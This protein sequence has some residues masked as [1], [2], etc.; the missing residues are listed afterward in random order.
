MQVPTFLHALHR[1]EL[2]FQAVGPRAE[3]VLLHDALYINK[4][5][6][7]LP[8]F[9]NILPADIN[10]RISRSDELSFTAT[11]PPSTLDDAFA[12]PTT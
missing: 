1:G 6:A 4:D 10:E 7:S 9:I 5:V 2:G 8:T 11:T 3:I 12:K